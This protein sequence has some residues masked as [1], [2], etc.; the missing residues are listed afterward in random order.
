M[1]GFLKKKVGAVF[2]R[3]VVCSE[4]VPNAKVTR[5]AR[6]DLALKRWAAARPFGILCIQVGAVAATAEQKQVGTEV[7]TRK[8]NSEEG[9]C[10]C[11]FVCV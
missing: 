10:V 11:V 6:G 1:P 9:R 5:V 4:I 7:N 8:E 3:F 2:F